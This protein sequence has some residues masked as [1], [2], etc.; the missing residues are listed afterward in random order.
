MYGHIL[1]CVLILHHIT[2]AAFIVFPVNAAYGDKAI[3]TA[4]GQ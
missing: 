1:Y 2:N 4:V 3:C